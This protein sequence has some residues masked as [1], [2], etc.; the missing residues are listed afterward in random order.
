LKLSGIVKSDGGVLRVRK[1]IYE[2]IF[3]P[4]WVRR[5]R[6][7]LLKQFLEVLRRYAPWIIGI[8]VALTL[9]TL[10]LQWRQSR[11]QLAD[12]V[13]SKERAVAQILNLEARSEPLFAPQLLL[14]SVKRA[15]T[16]EGPSHLAR[17]AP[18]LR[19]FIA[20][21]EHQGEVYALRSPPMAGKWPP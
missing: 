17:L 9:S 20:S 10:W 2:K 5:N 18:Q 6:T 19:R 16:V 11:L 15:S 12:A 13:G 1:R 3:T 7:D 21:L 8:L 4:A 14:E